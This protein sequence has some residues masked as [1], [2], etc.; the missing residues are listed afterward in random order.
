MTAPVSKLR[1][2][3]FGLRTLLVC[4][5]LCAFACSWLAVKMR[6]AQQQRKVAA[7]IEALDGAVSWTKESGP[8]WLRN[9]LGDHFFARVYIVS[10]DCTQVTDAE[11]EDLKE[12][13]ELK[14]LTMMQTQITDDGLAHL[15]CLNQ[16]QQLYLDHTRITDA[17]LENLKGLNQLQELHLSG[18]TEITDAGIENLKGLNHLKILSLASTQ[19]MDAGLDNLKALSQLQEL[20]LGGTRGVTDE[21]VKRL[22]QA[23]PNC[24]VYR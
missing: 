5:T 17:G 6:Q 15:R 19:V 2:Y 14:R 7:A 8:A 20:D 24:K 3:Q 12:L 22:Q 11:L 23:L 18:N 10:L 4:V 21:G 13:N 1:R 16:L 9:L